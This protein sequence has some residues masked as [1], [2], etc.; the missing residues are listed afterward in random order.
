MA[1][2]RQFHKSQSLDYTCTSKVCRI[3]AFQTAFK[4][5]WAMILLA[6]GVETHRFLPAPLTKKLALMA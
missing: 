5:F 1:P 3:I 6:C 2:G 4:G